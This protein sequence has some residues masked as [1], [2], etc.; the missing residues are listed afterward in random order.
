MSLTH[1][2]VLAACHGDGVN[3][4]LSTSWFAHAVCLTVRR[5]VR[6]QYTLAYNAKTDSDFTA[7]SPTL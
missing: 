3:K 1:H 5:R 2:L 4:D 7:G 6:H